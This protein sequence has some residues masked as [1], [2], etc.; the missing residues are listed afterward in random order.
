M[1]ECIFCK[2]AK[3]DT[4]SNIIYDNKYSIAFLDAHPATKGHTII[5]P[6]KHYENITEI[7]Q[8]ELC[9]VIKV[10]QKIAK[11]LKKYSG[12]I[13]FVQNNGERA[14]QVVPHLHF[15]LIPI[16][17]DEDFDLSWTSSRRTDIVLEEV[18]EEIKNLLNQ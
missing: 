9:E 10:V 5:I 16:A 18:Q 8:A 12:H 3:G 14:G 1:S 17:K 11:A 15:H 7:P 2:I 13:K 6:K 4:P